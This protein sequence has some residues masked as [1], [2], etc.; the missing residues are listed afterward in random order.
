M[1]YK[2]TFFHPEGDSVNDFRDSATKEAVWRAVD[3]MG[4]R[5]LFYPIA[6]V[7][8]DTTV[9]DAPAGLKFFV[10]KRIKTLSKFLKGEWETRKDE[11]CAMINAGVPMSEVYH[12]D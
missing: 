1:S 7:T 5:W 2:A 10:G 6:V 9:V 3:D 12:F 11:I 8:T 4:S